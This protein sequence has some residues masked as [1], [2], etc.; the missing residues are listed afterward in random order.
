LPAIQGGTADST[1]SQVQD[2][3]GPASLNNAIG[4]TADGETLWLADLETLNFADVIE[5]PDPASPALSA[6]YEYTDSLSETSA[7]AVITLN[8]P[9]SI[10]SA[11]MVNGFCPADKFD[12]KNPNASTNVADATAAINKWINTEYKRIRVTEGNVADTI[13][14]KFPANTCYR[15]DGTNAGGIVIAGKSNI[16]VEGDAYIVQDQNGNPL[17]SNNA[18]IIGVTPSALPNRDNNGNRYPEIKITTVF[19]VIRNLTL[20]E[21]SSKCAALRKWSISDN[22]YSNRRHIWVQG[23]NNVTL[24]NLR[25]EGENLKWDQEKKSNPNDDDDYASY[26]SP[27]EFEHAFSVY[28]GRNMTFENLQAR[29][30][31]GDGFYSQ[32]KTNGLT[33]KNFK[34]SYNGRQGV[35]FS[36]SENVVAENVQILNSRRAGFDLEPNS[37]WVV[38]NVLI[39]NSYI[40]GYHVAFAAGGRG[41]VDNIT[42]QNNKIAGPGVPWV[43]VSESDGVRRY[44]WKV[45]DNEVLNR[46][47]SPSPG[48]RFDNVTNIDVQRN[49]SR[50]VTTQSRN[51]VGLSG[52]KGTV[53]VKDNDF[54]GACWP[55]N[56]WVADGTL[57]VSGN[58]LSSLVDCFDF[59]DNNALDFAD[60]AWVAA[61]IFSQGNL[62][63][64][65]NQINING[66]GSRDIV[67]LITFADYVYHRDDA[68]FERKTT[69]GVMPAMPHASAL[70]LSSGGVAATLQSTSTNVPVGATATVSLLLTAPDDIPMRGAQFSILVPSTVKVTNLR[71]PIALGSNDMS[72]ALA[73]KE[74][75]ANTLATL[76]VVKYVETKGTLA[77]TYQ[78]V[79]ATLLTVTPHT[80]AASTGPVAIVSFDITPTVNGPFAIR[81]RN[82]AFSDP[83]P[84][85]IAS[86]AVNYLNTSALSGVTFTTDGTPA[87]CTNVEDVDCPDV[88]IGNLQ[89]FL[90]TIV[91]TEPNAN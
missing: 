7:Q 88:T 75:R 4:L 68:A 38:K 37:K 58:K 55:Y 47:G 69:R 67:D 22:C 18:D 35:A 5:A 64:A 79:Q 45:Y 60:V 80:L 41:A 74:G 34:V 20:S 66:F 8:A 78:D 42:I 73:T 57:T 54:D 71:S 2:S 31:W 83:F 11:P 27:W 51:P 3:D 24:K 82:A 77:G 1:F 19:K 36:Q 46:L 43:F 61:R 29:G 48:M 30:I 91:R 52:V 63:I 62:G 39:K 50:I 76:K 13:V 23:G 15:L 53:I 81:F 33:L 9:S 40:R 90:P 89:T 65:R 10:P 56:G 70:D 86:D 14:F 84:Q 28:G 59:I 32:G 49:R 26:F 6:G 25:V 87:T 12:P 44:D 17:P 21:I 72:Q 16:R 85:A